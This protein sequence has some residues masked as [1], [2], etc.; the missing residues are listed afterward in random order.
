MKV[1]A[2]IGVLALAMIFGLAAGAV[3]AGEEAEPVLSVEEWV[4]AKGLKVS[5]KDRNGQILTHFAAGE[6]RVDVLEWLKRQR[7]DVNAKD[8]N[9]RAPMHWAARGGHVKAMQWLKENGADASAKDSRDETPMQKAE[10]A[11]HVEAVKWLKA[12]MGQARPATPSKAPATMEKG[13]QP[14]TTLR[15]ALGQPL[16]GFVGDEYDGVSLRDVARDITEK[17]N[18]VVK[19][20]VRP[21]ES[22]EYPDVILRISRPEEMTL[23]NVLKWIEASI[24]GDTEWRLTIGQ[25]DIL[26]TES[27]TSATPPYP[28]TYRLPVW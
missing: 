2:V 9:D 23:A 3:A 25:N 11:G 6:G 26:F 7:A 1:L 13:P 21:P 22:G 28:V 27:K 17:T 19:V 8:G 12:N 4:K 14:A 24:S 5:E 15:K 18:G 10:A 16:P 20:F